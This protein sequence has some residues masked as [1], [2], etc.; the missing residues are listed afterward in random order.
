MF[1][2]L[3]FWNY[4]MLFEKKYVLINF[5][6]LSILLNYLSNG[7]NS[8]SKI[9]QSDCSMGILLLHKNSYFSFFYSDNRDFQFIKNEKLN[10]V[11]YA[12]VI[13][14]HS[15]C[16]Q[17]CKRKIEKK[18]D[19]KQ[20]IKI[21]DWGHRSSKLRVFFKSIKTEDDANGNICV[22]EDRATALKYCTGCEYNEEQHR[23]YRW[24]TLI[25]QIA[26]SFRFDSMQFPGMVSDRSIEI[27][28]ENPF[29]NIWMILL[30]NA[31]DW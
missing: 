11:L 15:R 13:N 19:E 5:S 6:C 21:Y 23:K 18:K 12:S 9:Q 31:Y 14:A 25:F 7:Y 4:F 10:I 1:H 28:E 26:L 27:S 24:M 2:F 20:I 22:T 8:V 17:W 29:Q 30:S 3:F 16:R